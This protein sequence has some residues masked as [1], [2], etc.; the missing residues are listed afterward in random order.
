MMQM[1]ELIMSED[2]LMKNLIRLIRVSKTL[3]LCLRSTLITSMQPMQEVHVKISEETLQ[4]LL[5]TII[6]L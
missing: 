6:W 3:P 1:Q 4:R 5:M 2:A